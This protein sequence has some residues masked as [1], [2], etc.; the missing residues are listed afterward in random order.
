MWARKS[1][2]MRY[3]KIPLV[4]IFTENTKNIPGQRTCDGKTL[5]HKTQ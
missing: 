2:K 3:F 4:E 1:N 5:G